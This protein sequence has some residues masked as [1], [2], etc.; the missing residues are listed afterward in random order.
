M[1]LKAGEIT[2]IC[3]FPLQRSAKS[4]VMNQSTL[5]IKKTKDPRKM[6][7]PKTKKRKEKKT[8]KIF[9]NKNKASPKVRYKIV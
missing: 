2:L 3:L 6:F 4:M 5:N 7:H 8:R 9:A 1:T